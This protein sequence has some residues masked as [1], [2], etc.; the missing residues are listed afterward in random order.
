MK[1]LVQP[2]TKLDIGQQG[3][4]PSDALATLRGIAADA[5][6]TVRTLDRLRTQYEANEWQ[7]PNATFVALDQAAAAAHDLAVAARAAA[8]A[9]VDNKLIDH[10][11][12]EPPESLLDL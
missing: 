6:D 12:A 4:P 1:D 9:I 8:T 11:A 7:R 10:G 2:R 3:T 5:E